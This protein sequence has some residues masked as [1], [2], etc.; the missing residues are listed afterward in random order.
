L[1][2]KEG[3]EKFEGK[4]EDRRGGSVSLRILKWLLGSGMNR[5]K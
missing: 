1:E 3:N 2:L 4:D 5:E